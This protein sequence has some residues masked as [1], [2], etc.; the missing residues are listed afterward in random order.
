MHRSRK[1]G[2]QPTLNLQS[3]LQNVRRDA[4]DT[5]AVAVRG[6]SNAGVLQSGHTLVLTE[7]PQPSIN[8]KY[9][10]TAIEHEVQQQ[11]AYRSRN[12]V[13]AG[14]YRNTFLAQP[15]SLAYRAS[16]LT[17]R[18]RV[19]GLLT[20]KVVVPAGEDSYMDKFGRVCVQFWWDRDRKAN[21]TDNTLLRVAQ[22]WAGK[23]WGT[24]FWP[25]VDDEVLID[26]LEG[27]PDAPV[28]VGSLYNGA[29][30]P[31]YNP[32]SEYTRSGILT[33]SSKTGSSGNANELRF[34]D[35]SGA[36]QIFINAER[37]MDLRVEHDARTF[38]RKRTAHHHQA[39]A[40]AIHRGGQG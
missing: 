31:K 9:L 16:Q 12:T 29:N 3:H 32:A 18:P 11:P 15:A 14:P 36:E 38:R 30:M 5:G 34:E 26:F 25:R 23:G 1:S 21:Q 37:D 40:A 13:P 8:G 39:K 2:I 33:R 28:V 20:G 4:G 17:P 35:R 27:D 7:Y 22:P 24:Y 6:A 10:L 19:H